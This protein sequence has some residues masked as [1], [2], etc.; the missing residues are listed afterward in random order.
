MQYTHFDNGKCDILGVQR[1]ELAN[2]D[3]ARMT[4]NVN[5]AFAVN[6]WGHMSDKPT[7]DNM[8]I[9]GPTGSGK[10]MAARLAH[11]PHFVFDK[12][13]GWIGYNGEQC[14]IFEDVEPK[15]R[16]TH[17]LETA[18]HFPAKVCLSHSPM[19]RGTM[20]KPWVC[21]PI[22]P[23]MVIVT[24]TYDIEDI[25]RDRNERQ[26][27]L[28]LFGK[29]ESMHTNQHNHVWKATSE[30]ESELSADP[31]P[32]MD[33][34]ELDDLT[35]RLDYLCTLEEGWDGDDGQPV[36]EQVATLAKKVL[37]KLSM[38]ET[39]RLFATG[40]GGIDLHWQKANV[41]CTVWQYYFAVHQIR[42]SK[43][44]FAG[45][46]NNED[47]IVSMLCNYFDDDPTKKDLDGDDGR[48][49]EKQAATP[50]EQALDS[51]SSAFMKHCCHSYL[52]VTS[53]PEL[54][55]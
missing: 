37:N 15:R 13:A 36:E 28:R 16:N 39:P 24:S 40:D 14:V 45:E 46:A 9:T 2:N 30:T 8:W 48:S 53:F 44:I 22:N 43:L 10:S 3:N 33:V 6:N 26:R 23:K 47:D 27:A 5:S 34:G 54:R 11:T 12:L 49:I 21:T 31:T 50:A 32:A 1:N 42:P 41:L 4:K 51:L 20:H 38:F 19:T 25:F 17:I 55:E 29:V 7:L 18:D 52:D 35:R